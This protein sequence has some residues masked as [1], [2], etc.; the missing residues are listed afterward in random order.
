VPHAVLA[1]PVWHAPFASQQPFW[2]VFASQTHAPSTHSC[3]QLHTT[4]A[5]PFEPHRPFQIGVMHSVPSQQPVGQFVASQY[6]VQT[7]FVHAVF[8]S[9]VKQYPPPA[10]HAALSVPGWHVR[11]ASQQ[12]SGQL[13]ASHWQKPLTHSCP[14]AHATHA[15]PAKP[16]CAFDI[17]VTH[18]VPSQQPLWQSL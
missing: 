11:D 16:H 10:P 12:P 3:P 13:V 15:A 1:R 5:L 6:G 4:Q 18:V 17:A 14:V 7:W 8:S 2:H 9:Q